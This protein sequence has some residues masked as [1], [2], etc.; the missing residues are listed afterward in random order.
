MTAPRTENASLA[1]RTI[2][3]VQNDMDGTGPLQRRISQA[4][5]TVMIADSLTRAL[6]IAR[7]AALDD[8]VID[9]DFAGSDEIVDVLRE[10]RI[11]YVF[12]PAACLHW[13]AAANEVSMPLV[14]H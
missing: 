13:I 2:L 9:I 14:K 3:I 11:R 12:C 6:L 5:G 8:A 1:A 4:G 10:R 7:N